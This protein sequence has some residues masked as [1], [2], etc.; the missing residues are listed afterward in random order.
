MDIRFSNMSDDYIYKAYMSENSNLIKMYL[1][2]GDEATYHKQSALLLEKYKGTI[3]EE[4]EATNVEDDKLIAEYMCKQA[5]IGEQY[6]GVAWDEKMEELAKQYKGTIV[7]KYLQETEEDLVAEIL[8]IEEIMQIQ[9]ANDFVVA[10]M[11]YL[12]DKCE[13]GDNLDALTEYEKTVFY[14][15][16]M[17]SEVHSK[18]FKEYLKSEDFPGYDVLEKAL[19]VIGANAVYEILQDAKK[20]PRRMSFD[21]IDG[22][23][24]EYPDNLE[25]L[26]M[27]YIKN[28]GV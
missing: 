17:N 27:N 16:T 8:P 26:I 22:R 1:L 11:D 14:V 21:K 7:E 3:V 15:D 23:L 6:D 9:D 12:N 2:K 28:V 5:I 13:Y 19:Q 4:M 24:Y 25:Q 18:G 20:R 10:Y